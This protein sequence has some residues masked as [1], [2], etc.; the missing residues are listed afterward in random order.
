MT[1]ARSVNRKAIK[2]KVVIDIIELRYNSSFDL[3]DQ[4][5]W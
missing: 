3:Q 4:S 2:G 1:R 5:F